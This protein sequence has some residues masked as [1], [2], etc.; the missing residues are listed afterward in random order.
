MDIFLREAVEKYL[1]NGLVDDNILKT[2]ERRQKF[3]ELLSEPVYEG[4]NTVLQGS[5]G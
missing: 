4:W 1:S 5:N 2:R 3:R